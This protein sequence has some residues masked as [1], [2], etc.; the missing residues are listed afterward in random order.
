MIS[1]K[2]ICELLSALLPQGRLNGCFE[3][4]AEI[5]HMTGGQ[6]L[7]TTDEFSAE[8]LFRENEPYLLGWNIAAG[9]I[10]DIL[11][12]G[13]V[14]LY[15]A[16]ALTVDPRWDAE[17]LSQFGCGVR[18]VLIATGAQFIGGDCGRSEL[19]RC[20][21]SV[22]GS[23]EGRP[24][25]RRGAAPGDAIYLSGSIGAGNREAALKLQADPN[26]QRTDPTKT[27]FPLRLQ[28]SAIMRKYASACIDTSDGVWAALNTLADL[29]GCGYVVAD[30][31]YFAPA[32]QLCQHV[33]LPKTLLFLGE[34]GE[35][36]LL[37]TLRPEQEPLFLAE[38]QTSSGHFHRLGHI[39]S[40]ERTLREDGQVID[41]SSLQIQA[42][43]YE[44]PQRYV[45]ALIR[46]LERWPTATSKCQ[47]GERS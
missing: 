28:E 12:C 5:I 10:S 45:A 3:S 15:Y 31:P 23:C 19:W 18:D 17:Y 22:I 37:F 33:S 27:Q 34:S 43:D 32:V 47:T 40:S 13:G 4:D 1:E 35:Y 9:A 36:E 44:N 30:L 6:C 46:W 39:T 41:L 24:I 29:N 11:A 2:A 14:P 20:T 16:H 26:V 25:L 42:R 8:D 21:V 7:F 38:A